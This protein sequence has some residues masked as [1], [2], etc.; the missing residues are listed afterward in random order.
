QDDLNN[1]S[2][3]GFYASGD[4]IGRTGAETAFEDSLRGTKGSQSYR[5]DAAGNPTQLIDQTAPVNGL[6]VKLTLDLKIQQA[7]DSILPQIIASARSI[8][9][10]YCDAGALVCLDVATGGILGAS[11]Y[12]TFFPEA[13][14]QGI[15]QDLWDSLTSPD[16]LYP[17]TNRVTSGQYP[18]A[19]TFKSFISMAGLENG[20]ILSDTT[21]D[22]KGYWIGY[23]ENWRQWCW[24]HAGHGVLGLEEA[25]N[26]SCDVYFY[27]TGDR[28]W[29]QWVKSDL[30]DVDRPNPLQE[31]LRTFGFGSETG[32]DIGGEAKGRVPDAAWKKQAFSETPEDAQWQGG[33]MTNLVIGQGDILVTPLQI[34]NGYSGIARRKMLK[35]HLFLESV[36]AAGQTVESY[37]VRESDVQ[38]IIEPA[39]VA[40]VEEGLSRVVKRL[41]GD[42]LKLPVAV[43]G[44]TGT[45]EVIAAKETC[46]WFVCYAPADAPEYCVACVVEQAGT[47]DSVALQAVQHVLAAIYD[48]DIGPVRAG[49]G[50]AER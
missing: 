16:S 13:F 17:L 43:R 49:P 46:S 29:Q 36:D 37:A 22:C 21:S 2:S 10:I 24:L 9:R 8:G 31:Y 33:D 45:G 47:G 35:P 27:D 1:D 18:A 14:T 5:T 20:M 34:A 26:Q 30:K 39:Y 50:T 19:S 41:G 42:F 11:S 4:E 15:S 28:F 7:V 44:K 23:G 3:Q 6:D 32:L 12:P 25:I 48:V 40:R 38:P